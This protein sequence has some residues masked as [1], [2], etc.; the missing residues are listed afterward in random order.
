MSISRLLSDNNEQQA[1]AEPSREFVHQQP[2]RASAFHST[3]S[4]AYAP[5]QESERSSA[6]AS[7][8]AAPVRQNGI[9]DLLNH[10]TEISRSPHPSE[11]SSQASSL[12]PSEPK[13]IRTNHFNQ[14]MQ[15]IPF[16]LMILFHNRSQDIA[17]PILTESNVSHHLFWSKRPFFLTPFLTFLCLFCFFLDS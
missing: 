10:G 14:R 3:A 6:F 12:P 8:H 15:W 9:N 5:H 1:Q 2:V 4:S 17:L 7:V 11:S 13:V 16:T